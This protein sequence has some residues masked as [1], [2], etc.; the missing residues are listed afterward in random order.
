MRADMLQRTIMKVMFTPARAGGCLQPGM[1]YM[2][3]QIRPAPRDLSRQS[4]DNIATTLD[5][6][7]ALE[8]GGALGSFTW[9]A[10]DRLLDE[11]GLRIA[12]VS[13]TSAGA[14]NA[15]MLVHGLVEDGPKGAK[16]LLETFWKRVAI[17]A[18]SFPGPEDTHE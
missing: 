2:T 18:G 11:P 8:G 9:G 15:A 10:L 1:G 12:A 5:V 17:A 3:M 4:P 16:A 7:L 13:G 14:M 6:T